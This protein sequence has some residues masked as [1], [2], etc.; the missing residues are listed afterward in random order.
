MLK[1]LQKTTII[2][3]PYFRKLY[4]TTDGD[5]NEIKIERRLL[6]EIIEQKTLK[7]CLASQIQNFCTFWFWLIDTYQQGPTKAERC[8]NKFHLFRESFWARFFAQCYV[9]RFSWF[10]SKE[11]SFILKDFRIRLNILL[12]PDIA[13]GYSVANV[14][15][16]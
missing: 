13:S 3:Q 12:R 10:S 8:L 6:W 1:Y 5:L 7:V 14:A 16:T 9:C 15:F 2:I 4:L 11:E